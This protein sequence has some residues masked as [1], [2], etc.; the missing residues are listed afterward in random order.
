[1]KDI[2]LI[3]VILSFLF[4]NIN[5]ALSSELTKK[6]ELIGNPYKMKYVSIEDTYSRNVWDLQTYNGKLFIGAGNSSNQGPSQNSGPLPLISYLPVKDKF[7]NEGIIYDDQID[8]FNLLNNKLYIPGHDATGSWKWGNFY[9][10]DK[11]KPLQMYRNIPAGLHLY[12]MA[13]IKGKLYSAIGLDEGA[14]VGVTTDG[15][16]NWKIH[17]LGRSRV[18]AFMQIGNTLF[19]TKK[20]KRTSKP[21][22]SIAQLMDNGE[23]SARYDLSLYKMFPKTKFEH[24]YSRL[25]RSINLGSS[26]IYVGA[27]KY[28]DHQSKPFGLYQAFLKNSQ[29]SVNKINLGK[30][31]IARDIIKRGNTLYVIATLQTKDS[32]KNMI[33]KGT[34]HKTKG[35]Q[36]IEWKKLLSFDYP[37]FA[38]SFEELN[39][40]FYFGMGSDLDEPEKWKKSEMLP[41]TGNILRIKKVF[42]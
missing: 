12:D 38:R 8:I 5:T 11:N 21:Y 6:L 29:L 17:K 20:F 23:F 36:L 25:I 30:H 35:W 9:I 40:D 13:L 10:K 34:K 7:I 41:Q 39:G 32:I 24:K 27:Y 4:T 16:E 15:G 31:L 19:A 42:F 33:F 28:N 26:A 3:I 14:A 18:Y 1:M 37:T 2:K 22:F